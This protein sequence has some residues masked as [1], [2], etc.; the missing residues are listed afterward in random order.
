MPSDVLNIVQHHQAEGPGYIKSWA[1]ARDIPIRIY[2]ATLGELPV[3]DASHC[4]LLG[5][6]ASVLR[7][8]DW[9]LHEQRWL[10]LALAHSTPMFAIC[11]GAQ[12]LAHSLGAKISALAK[13]ELGW[14]NIEINNER[15]AFLQWHEDQFS[16]PLG[17]ELIAQGSSCPV[18][19][20]RSQ[21]AQQIGLQFHP[22]WDIATLQNMASAMTLP[23]PLKNVQ[24]DD[25]RFAKAERWLFAQ[26]DGWWA[27]SVGEQQS[28]RIKPRATP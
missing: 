27:S 19:G 12:L 2:Q 17:A 14:C 11:L 20:Y 13:P 24:A 16:K 8:P 7:P 23:E 22:E 25:S 3:L 10:N 28:L 4:I 18:Q 9:M 6:P 26:L 5:G 15:H 1:Q 21:N